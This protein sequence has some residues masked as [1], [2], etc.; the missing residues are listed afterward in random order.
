[1]H[2]IEIRRVPLEV[3]RIINDKTTLANSVTPA[4]ISGLMEEQYTRLRSLYEPSTVIESQ[5]SN[6]DNSSRQL[7]MWSG[8]FHL[9]PEDYELPKVGLLI[10]WQQWWLGKPESRIPPLR[11]V[12]A[13]D[14]KKDKKRY[15]DL[16]FIMKNMERVVENEGMSLSQP[17]IH[18][19]NE[20]YD[21][22][23]EI[24]SLAQTSAKNRQRRTG[25]IIWTT[26]VKELRNMK[27]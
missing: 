9:L 13:R 14:F 18:Q 5:T 12:T 17:S 21:M 11:N 1:M 3:E 7:Y 6:L 23:V 4:F 8:S 2:T 26:V 19:L 25:Q 16:K 15:S 24:L 20:S 10:M 27:T 22:A